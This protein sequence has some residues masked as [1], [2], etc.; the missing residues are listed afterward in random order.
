VLSAV[1]HDRSLSS[2]ARAFLDTTTM[3]RLGIVARTIPHYVRLL[4]APA[5]LSA[6]YAPN[7]IDPRPGFSLAGTIGVGLIVAFAVG[8]TVVLRRR[9]W[10]VVAFALL[11]IPIT[12]APISNVLFPS[13]IV[14]A[15]RT[16]YLTS[17]GVCLIAGAAAERFLLI[18]P[19]MVA[20]ATASVVLALGVRT[21][22]RTP[23]WR[24]DRTYALTLLA[25]RPEAYEAHL[26]VGRALKG[27]NLLDQAERELTI[28][29]Q[30]FP[31]DSL[32]YREA[33]DLAERQQRPALAAALRDSARIARTLPYPST[34][35]KA[36]QRR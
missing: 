17:V 30:L 28:A 19:A 27:A 18:R 13:G 15:E 1:F 36:G 8:L 26:A 14:L 12:L 32:I 21:W 3:E 10:P 5:N 16:L 20:A 33:A 24:D 25:D 6:S 23:V 34:A 2:P 7:V 22:T 35:L 9:R 31:R 11:W 29:R 4:V